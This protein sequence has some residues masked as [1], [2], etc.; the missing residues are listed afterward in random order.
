MKKLFLILGFAMFMGGFTLAQSTE[1]KSKKVAEGNTSS[2]FGKYTIEVQNEPVMIDGEQVKSYKITYENSP[3]SV[4][5][6]VD[7][8]ESCKN[9]I[10]VSDNLSVMY[11]CNG[12]YFG[13]NKIDKKYNKDGFVTNVKNL[14]LSN[15]Y[16]QKIIVQGMQEEVNATALVA[17][18]F[19]DLL[20]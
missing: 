13:V 9:Y 6:I 20:K 12:V 17:S 3:I 14:N 18:Y 8:E 5:V 16:H 1:A 19:P 4:V 2:P 7:K 10:V 15:F 11:T